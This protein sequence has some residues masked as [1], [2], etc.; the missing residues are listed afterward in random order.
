MGGVEEDK[1]VVLIDHVDS[2]DEGREVGGGCG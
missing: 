2:Q 1:V